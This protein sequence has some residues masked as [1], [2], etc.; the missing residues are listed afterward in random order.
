MG[1]FF[2]TAL[3]LIMSACSCLALRPHYQIPTVHFGLTLGYNNVNYN[4]IALQGDIADPAPNDDRVTCNGIEAGIFYE[5]RGLYFSRQNWF[6][7]A[8]L[9]YRSNSF[10]AVEELGPGEQD[11]DIQGRELRREFDYEGLNLNLIYNFYLSRDFPFSIG[12][13]L[14]LSLPF[15]YKLRETI[16][17]INPDEEDGP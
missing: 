1:R 5:Y 15:N 4:N 9:T 11:I 2:I 6:L 7:R 8:V 17:D 12:A 10:D 16:A 14:N 3:L 13:G